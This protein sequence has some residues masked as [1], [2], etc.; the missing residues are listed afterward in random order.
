MV[1]HCWVFT[2]KE[3]KCLY[4]KGNVECTF[5]SSFCIRVDGGVIL[6]STVIN[7]PKSVLDI[8]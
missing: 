6:V 3:L 5:L 7:V 2:G 8:L 1:I 4:L